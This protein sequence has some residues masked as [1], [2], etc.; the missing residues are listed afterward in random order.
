M[1]DKVDGGQHI[2]VRPKSEMLGEDIIYVYIYIYATG[3]RAAIELHR[4]KKR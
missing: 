3:A 2:R 4:T 1:V